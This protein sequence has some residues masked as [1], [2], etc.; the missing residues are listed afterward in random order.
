[1]IIVLI[2]STSFSPMVYAKKNVDDVSSDHPK[3]K[4]LKRDTE[5]PFKA[6]LVGFMERLVERFP[7]LASLPVFQKL[8]GNE[9]NSNSSSSDTSEDD[10]N[11][12]QS[13]TSN[14]NDNSDTDS[15]GGRFIDRIIRRFHRSP[16]HSGFQD[17]SG[18]EEESDD[19]DSQEDEGS[20]TGSADGESNSS[21][22]KD[23]S[24][25]GVN[26]IDN[27]TKWVI[28]ESGHLQITGNISIEIANGMFYVDNHTI[29]L[30]G[31]F[32]LESKDDSVDIWWNLTQ[33]FF[34]INGS[35]HFEIENLY[36][37]VD[38]KLVVKINSLI[39]DGQGYF[40]INR[41]GDER[42]LFLNGVR[43]LESLSVSID[44]ER[45]NIP[46]KYLS[47]SFNLSSVNQA[48]EFSIQWGKNGFSADGFY[49]GNT[50]LDIYD[51]C[52]IHKKFRIYA[53]L[54]SFYN[55]ADFEFI[56]AGETTLCSIVSDDLRV[57]GL[58]L[59]YGNYSLFLNSTEVHG[60]LNLTL[61]IDGTGD[62][63]VTARDGYI[64]IS[65]NMVMNVNTTIDV[66]GI[67]VKL[68]GELTVETNSD[69]I[70]I[71]WNTT[72]GFFKI[73]STSLSVLGN[74]HVAIEE[75]WLELNLGNI[76]MD[77][78]AS[79]T[80]DKVNGHSH[81]KFDGII[82]LRAFDFTVTGNIKDNSITL[83]IG[84][85]YFGADGNVDLLW[86]NGISNL[87]AYASCDYGLIIHNISA[88]AAGISGEVSTLTLQ[89]EWKLS[90]NNTR[91]LF[92]VNGS[93]Q[94]QDFS[95]GNVMSTCYLYA[96]GS[97]KILVKGG[98]IELWLSGGSSLYIGE[99]PLGSFTLSARG[100]LYARI[101]LTTGEIYGEFGFRGWIF[102]K[103]I[104]V[105]FSGYGNFT[106]RGDWLVIRTTIDFG[107]S[108]SMR[109][110]F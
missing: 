101:D 96:S 78:E 68:Q 62:E 110:T 23:I 93:L 102:M 7:K 75:D 86:N 74:L 52:L 76:I 15:K 60:V 80:L 53:D 49:T 20:E 88:A 47:G 79:I 72:R 94:L 39:I 12:S 69:S 100:K 108:F 71:W 105:T 87:T 65:G 33:G 107:V 36:F 17:L 45:E 84:S 46:L 30:S 104:M 41:F 67:T 89:G 77:S 63:Y 2:L 44:V 92:T 24:G 51:F 61:H 1:M 18:T 85:I 55:T 50:H 34:K 10:E 4:V 9:E 54:V 31:K 21:T 14:I 32:H 64:I 99:G 91:L 90:Y 11:D 40:T 43:E 109:F 106:L 97:V 35:R 38:G 73:T 56:Q 98:V 19:D 66:N 48:N 6:L 28:P 8:L 83:H 37:D 16:F 27:S 59:K 29:L 3:I 25:S 70:E 58:Y 57:S 95:V 81:L 82:S 13:N 26:E 103:N 42:G 22:S 5:R